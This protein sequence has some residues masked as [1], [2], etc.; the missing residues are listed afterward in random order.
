MIRLEGLLSLKDV[1][2][3]FKNKCG[4]TLETQGVS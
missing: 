3:R 4:T 1:T 2:F